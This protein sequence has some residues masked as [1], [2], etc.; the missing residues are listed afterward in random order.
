MSTSLF[1]AA[2]AERKVN[3]VE[4]QAGLLFG[5]LKPLQ[6]LEENLSRNISEIKEL[7]SQARKQAAS[8]SSL[9]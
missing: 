2:S 9:F 6:V 4:V 5:R 1:T 8:V 7:I 3:E